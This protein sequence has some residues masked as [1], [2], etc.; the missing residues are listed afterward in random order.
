MLNRVWFGLETCLQNS[1]TV[2]SQNRTEKLPAGSG[3]KK[4]NKVEWE[5]TQNG[6]QI[7]NGIA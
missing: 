1:F 5:P 7:Q 4:I 3:L 2:V 6:V